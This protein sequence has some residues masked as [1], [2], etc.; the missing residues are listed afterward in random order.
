M[1]LERGDVRVIINEGSENISEK[2]EIK[3]GD[4][5]VSILSNNPGYN[6]L[7]FWSK[8]YIYTKAYSYRKQTKK[9]LYYDLN[10]KDL[11]ILCTH[12]LTIL[13]YLL[14]QHIQII[15]SIRPKTHFSLYS[16]ENDNSF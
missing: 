13:M 10:D 11:M 4:N 8:N 16:L 7:N 9:K 14:L 3:K 6:T 5:W 2:I 12:L 1:I 15:H